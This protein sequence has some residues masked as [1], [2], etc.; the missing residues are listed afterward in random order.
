V[1]SRT[2]LGQRG[3]CWTK[4]CVGTIRLPGVYE[5][6]SRYCDTAPRDC[7]ACVWYRSI[8][9]CHGYNC[10]EVRNAARWS[11]DHSGPKHRA[12]TAN[13]RF[14]IWFTFSTDSE[15]CIQRR[16]HN[17]VVEQHVASVRTIEQ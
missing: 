5:Y 6:D 11:R 15:P 16:R 9:A 13:R 3:A 4:L 8:K 7:G 17:S 12:Q 1:P 10:A 14:A 2:R